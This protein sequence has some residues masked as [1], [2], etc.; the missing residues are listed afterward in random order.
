MSNSN[1]KIKVK[2]SGVVGAIP[3][4]TFLETGELALNYADDKIYYKNASNQIVSYAPS[5]TLS[6]D[7]TGPTSNTAISATT[8]TG[9][10]LTNYTSTTGTITTSDTILGAIGKLNGNIALKLDKVATIDTSITG[11]GKTFA[12][13]DNGKIFHATGTN[14]LVLP[15]WSS[16]TAGW[17]IGIVNVGGSSLTVNRSNSDTINNALT[18]FTNTISYSAVYIYKSSTTNSFVAI[19]MLS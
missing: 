14:T 6:G 9:K 18:T 7:V 15:A 5:A 3:S 2:N 19:G 13:A 11:S 12:D 8:I 10:Q 1:A 16:I 4:S 17:S